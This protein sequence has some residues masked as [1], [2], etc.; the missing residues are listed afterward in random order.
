[1]ARGKGMSSAKASDRE[2]LATTGVKSLAGADDI[3]Q[4]SRQVKETKIGGHNFTP[5]ATEM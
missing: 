5:S 1:M 2:A 4:E 3:S